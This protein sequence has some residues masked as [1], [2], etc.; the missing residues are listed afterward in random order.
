MDPSSDV[1]PVVITAEDQPGLLQQLTTLGFTTVQARNAI[2]ALSQVSP[3]ASVLLRSNPPLQACIEYLILQVPECDLPQRFLPSLNSSG[4]FVTSTHAGSDSLKIRWAEEKAVKECGWPVHVVKEC[5]AHEKLSS[6]WELLVSVLNRRLI[7]DDWRNVT[8]QEQYYHSIGEDEA[9]A[10]GSYRNE[11]N[12]L[13]VP[14]PIAPLKLVIVPSSQGKFRSDYPP[15]L[16]VVS[17]SVPAYIRLY[18]ASKLLDELKSGSLPE[19]DESLLMGAMRL[20][21]EEWVSIEDTGPPDMAALL[22]NLTPEEQQ[23]PLGEDTKSAPE[24]NKP[25][26]RRRRATRRQDDRSD[27]RVEENFTKLTASGKYG[28][29]LAS[30]RKLPAFAAQ[31]QFLGLLEKNR[32]VVVVGETGTWFPWPRTCRDL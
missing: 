19:E 17:P 15:A 3:I 27:S 11:N 5:M 14:M 10:F 25:N 28:E 13:V 26:G 20:L 21:E 2:A 18:L 12:E 9:E 6:D 24:G 22:Q 32:C 29:I 16:Y 8:Q 30:R 31:A 23:E 1:A 4:S 7:G